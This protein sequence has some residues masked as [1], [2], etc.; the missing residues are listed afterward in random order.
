MQKFKVWTAFVEIKPVDVISES[1]HYVFLPHGREAKL[2]STSA[3]LDTFEEARSWLLSKK[4]EEL[5]K[6]FNKIYHIAQ[7]IKDIKNLETTSGE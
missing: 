3:Y 6:V 2:T 7:E 5:Q 1:E 4:Q